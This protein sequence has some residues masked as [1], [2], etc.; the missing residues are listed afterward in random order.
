MKEVLL[1]DIGRVVATYV[2]LLLCDLRKLFNSRMIP[3]KALSVSEECLRDGKRGRGFILQ[4]R[5]HRAQVLVL[6]LNV[7]IWLN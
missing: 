1:N 5:F 6:R 3:C 2:P 7:E 4:G